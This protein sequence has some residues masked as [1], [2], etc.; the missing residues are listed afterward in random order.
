M[1]V[2]LTALGAQ[3]GGSTEPQPPS[4]PVPATSAG[5]FSVVAALAELPAELVDEAP[6]VTMGDVTAVTEAAGLTVPDPTSEDFVEDYIHWLLAITGTSTTPPADGDPQFAP[7]MVVPPDEFS[8][9]ASMAE[10]LDA[11]VGFT[12]ADVEWFADVGLP[13]SGFSVF[14]GSFDESTLSPDLA[15]VVDGVVT[16]GEGEDLSLDPEATS[17]LSRIGQPQRLAYSNGRIAVSPETALV[18]TWLAGTDAAADID[19][20]LVAVATALD[21]AGVMSAALGELGDLDDA[22]GPNATPEQREAVIAALGDAVLGEGFDDAVGIGWRPVDGEPV[23]TIVYVL[24]DDATDDDAAAAVDNVRQLFDEGTSIQTRSPLTDY[25]SLDEV[26][27]DGSTVVA[28]VRPGPEGIPMTL[29]RM[30]TIADLPF[31]TL[32]D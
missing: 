1:S 20:D 17:P 9:L 12:F 2:T 11:A 18:S 15:P 26:G 8:L 22:L 10:E 7:A 3:P 5:E 24:D 4:S 16:L 19:D 13:P 31:V 6:L 25:L 28:T 14:G 27:T 32:D 30:L 21:E 23:M 29:L